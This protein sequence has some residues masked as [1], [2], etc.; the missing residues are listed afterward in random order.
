MTRQ[1]SREIGDFVEARTFR[2]RVMLAVGILAHYIILRSTYSMPG[3]QQYGTIG[4]DNTPFTVQKARPTFLNLTLAFG[5]APSTCLPPS[6]LIYG[7][8]SLQR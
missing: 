5:H 2:L 3:V 1:L 6:T 8:F 7:Q 4:E